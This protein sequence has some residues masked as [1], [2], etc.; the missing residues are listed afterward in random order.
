M[1]AAGMLF[2]RIVAPLPDE[3]TGPPGPFVL[4]E[5]GTEVFGIAFKRNRTAAGS[6]HFSVVQSP[7]LAEWSTT[8]LKLVSITDFDAEHELVAFRSMAPMATMDRQFL[9][10]C[11]Y[12]LNPDLWC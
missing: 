9:A 5:S 11:R 10:S 2:E 12:S 3:Y 7:D 8:D 4:G 1:R 6:T